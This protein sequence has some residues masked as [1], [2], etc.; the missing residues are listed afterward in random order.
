MKWNEEGYDLVRYMFEEGRHFLCFVQVTNAVEHI[1]DLQ[2]FHRLAVK[3]S[4][5]LNVRLGVE[6]IVVSPVKTYLKNPTKILIKNR[7]SL[8]SF[9]LGSTESE[10]SQWT[11]VNVESCIKYLYFQRQ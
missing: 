11:G 1:A 10:W 2:Y 8:N 4:R 3:A 9:K 5:I 7:D 6:I